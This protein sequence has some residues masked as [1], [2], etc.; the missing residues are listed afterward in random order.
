MSKF[1]GMTKA[2]LA[3]MVEKLEAENL[4]LKA[5]RKRGSGRKLELLEVLAEGPASILDISNRM[6]V[7]TKNV[8]SLKCYLRKDGWGLINDEEGLTKI[9]K[10]KGDV[11]DRQF[12]L[13]HVAQ[14]RKVLEAQ[15]AK[16]EEGTEGGEEDTP[17]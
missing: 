17:E 4:A 2:Q 12:I 11:V 9:T 13:D 7:S 15:A 10:F 5:S 8:S 16:N 6:G 14:E 1:E 3:E